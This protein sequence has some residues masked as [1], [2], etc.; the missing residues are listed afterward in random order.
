MMGF[1]SGRASCGTPESYLGAMLVIQ[2]FGEV[3]Y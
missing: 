2:Q 1:A 3:E